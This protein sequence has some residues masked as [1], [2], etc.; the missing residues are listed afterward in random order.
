MNSTSRNASV[1]GFLLTAS[2]FPTLAPAQQQGF[3]P[4]PINDC[5]DYVNRALQQ[6]SL[7]RGCN[8]TGPRWTANG[9]EHMD[10][11]K[12]VTPAQRGHEDEQRFLGLDWCKN[13]QGPDPLIK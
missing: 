6:V 7:A 2:L 4:P 1:A 9:N 8:F 11:C 3:G 5:N 10:W 13:P 12:R